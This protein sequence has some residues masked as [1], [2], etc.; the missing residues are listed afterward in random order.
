MPVGK[1]PNARS[2]IEKLEREN[3]A[4]RQALHAIRRDPEAVLDVLDDVDDRFGTSLD[5]ITVDG[6]REGRFTAEEIA[7]RL[8]EVEVALGG[9]PV[10][11]EPTTA[12]D[13]RAMTAEQIADF[14]SDRALAILN[15]EDS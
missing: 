11:G 9:R 1:N 10:T 8:P 2:R 3:K 7:D 13:V 4:M 15:A 6:L 12:A 14:G 5:P